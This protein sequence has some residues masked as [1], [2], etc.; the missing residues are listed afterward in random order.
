MTYSRHSNIRKIIMKFNAKRFLKRQLPV[1]ACI[2]FL[3]LCGLF[4]WF[5]RSPALFPLLEG[6]GTPI[7]E[8]WIYHI[9]GVSGFDMEA[10]ISDQQIEELLALAP[11]RR[12]ASFRAVPCPAFE[13]HVTFEDKFYELI[14]GKN[15]CICVNG[16]SFYD[17]NDKETF[18]ADS[19][20]LFS[21]LYEY[22][23]SAGGEPIP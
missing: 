12:G 16:F 19:G 11:V 13:I 3:T 6:K 4:F 21:A 17:S 9:P 7:Y 15:G 22:H 20:E 10:N 8:V 18:W 5:H 14:V 23:I 1:C 2:L